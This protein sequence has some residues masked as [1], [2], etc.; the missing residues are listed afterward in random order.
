MDDDCD[1]VVDEAAPCDDDTVCTADACVDGACQF[2]EREREAYTCDEVDEDCDGVTDEDCRLHAT[3]RLWGGGFASGVDPTGRQGTTR[4]G[5]PRI[6]GSS[7]NGKWTI[8]SGLGPGGA[9]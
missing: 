2:I 8:T 6:Q 7:S 1:E 4:L 3:G 5:A 9:P